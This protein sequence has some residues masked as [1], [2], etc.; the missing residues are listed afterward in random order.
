MAV[1]LG[2]IAEDIRLVDFLRPAIGK[3]AGPGA[4]EL[5]RIEKIRGC[6]GR[7]LR[8]VYP[9]IRSECALVVVAADAKIEGKPVTHR[10]K[11]RAL[12]TFLGGRDPGLLPAVAAPSVE[13]WLLCDPTSFAAGISEGTGGRFR[14]L[15]EWPNPRSERSAKEALGRLIHEGCGG[16]L[17]RSGFEYAPEI[18]ARMDLLHAPNRSLAD[19]ARAFVERIARIA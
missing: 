16:H 10:R 18:V 9:A 7:R 15:A 2:I 1:S 12:E 4:V 5:L 6:R 11:A 14:K 19:W 17:P 13:A 8:D 3:L